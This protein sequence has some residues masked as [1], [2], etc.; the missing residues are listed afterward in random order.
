MRAEVRFLRRHPELRRQYGK[1][2]AL[3]EANPHH[4]SLRMHAL[5]GRHEGLHSV[6]INLSYRI[7]LELRISGQL[8]IPV[9]VGDH[10]D[11]YR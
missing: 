11:V 4:P 2:L 3:L 5:A 9:N 6:S 8:I 1:A 7:T 10:D